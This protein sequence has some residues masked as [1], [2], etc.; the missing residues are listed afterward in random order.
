M[1]TSIRIPPELHKIVAKLAID[2]EITAS[3]IWIEAMRKYL[4]L[5]A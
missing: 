1:Q 3:E 4:K 2:R 5:A